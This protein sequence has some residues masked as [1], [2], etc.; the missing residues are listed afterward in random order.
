M[1]KKTAITEENPFKETPKKERTTPPLRNP[2]H[3]NRI[4]VQFDIEYGGHPG[5][6]KG[7]KSDTVPDLNLTVRQLLQNHTRNPQGDAVT[8][9]EPVYFDQEIPTITDLTDVAEYK[10]QLQERLKQVNDFIKQDSEEGNKKRAAEAE[11]TNKQL[12][13]DEEAEK[14]S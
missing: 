8:V 12:R 13:I 7:G 1:K 10:E 11:K 2:K 5:V 6:K 4:Q 9:R 3:K 14:A